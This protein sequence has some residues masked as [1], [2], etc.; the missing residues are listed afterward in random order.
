MK[1][2]AL[3][4]TSILLEL[5]RVPGRF[6]SEA[7]AKALEAELKQKRRDLEESLLLPLGAILET[8]NHIA[9]LPD[10]D[11]RRNFAMRFVGLVELALKNQAP[12]VAAVRTDDA[13]LRA[14][15]GEFVAW[16]QPH[17]REFTDLSIKL[18]WDRQCRLHPGRRVYV[19]SL[20]AHLASFDRAPTLS[21]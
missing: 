19:W 20:D 8:G 1:A 12:F 2:V 6:R 16:V 14:W 10:G 17:A 15:C 3:L 18:E 11:Q 7:S 5:L 4:D 9:R 21:R 13:E